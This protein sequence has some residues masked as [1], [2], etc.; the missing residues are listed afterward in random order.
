MKQQITV[1]YDSPV[2]VVTG[3]ILWAIEPAERKILRTECPVCDGTRSLTVNGHTFA[4]PQCMLLARNT[5]FTHY[6]VR[7][8]RVCGIDVF[9]PNDYWKDADLPPKVVF[10]LFRKYG[11]GISECREYKIRPADIDTERFE[12]SLAQNFAFS[13]YARACE[14]ARDLNESENARLRDFNAERGTGFA[15]EWKETN[16][17]EEKAR[18]SIS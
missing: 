6:V 17:K 8:Y 15:F 18:G 13:S 1:E 2:K 10:T 4:C 3:M 16:D 11:R 12:S 7:K 14:L 9:T 5:V